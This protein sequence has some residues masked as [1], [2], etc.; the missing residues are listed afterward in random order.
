MRRFL[1][2]LLVV[3]ASMASADDGKEVL[4]RRLIDLTHF[5]E[6]FKE[7]DKACHEDPG[8]AAKKAY[9]RAPA[10]FGGI[11]PQSAYWPEVELAFATFF[12][13]SCGMVTP[14]AASDV[15]VHVY[16]EALS[17]A[18]LKLI[19]DF[20]TSPAGHKLLAAQPLMS[21][22]MAAQ[23]DALTKPITTQASAHY[24]ETLAILTAKYRAEPR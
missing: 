11:S 16:T 18:D 19:V 1:A 10:Q 9:M 21:K 13:A 17:L 24:A 8:A 14:S 2:V 23:L 22:A 12:G 3:T 6:Q 7:L 4:A 20:Y 15:F 5:D